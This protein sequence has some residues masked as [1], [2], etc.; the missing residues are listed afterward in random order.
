ML[1]NEWHALT[2]N[3]LLSHVLFEYHTISLSCLWG[4]IQIINKHIS[5]HLV[6]LLLSNIAI[7]LEV[8][9]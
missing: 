6:K 1:M 3:A 2:G 7:G 4:I 9:L 5:C 8:S